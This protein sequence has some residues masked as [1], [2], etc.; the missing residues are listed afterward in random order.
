MRHTLLSTTGLIGTSVVLLG[1]WSGDA[2]AWEPMRSDDGLELRWPAQTEFSICPAVRSELEQSAIL[3]AGVWWNQ[4]G[5]RSRL[6]VGVGCALSSSDGISSVVSE[7]DQWPAEFGPSEL[8]VAL[9][10]HTFTPDGTITDSDILLNAVEFEFTEHGDEQSFSAEHVVAHELG[11]VLGLGHPCGDTQ[12]QW[13]SCFALSSE[14]IAELEPALMFP[15]RSVGPRQTQLAADDLEGLTSLFALSQAPSPTLCGSRA[16]AQALDAS[17]IPLSWKEIDTLES[18]LLAGDEPL[19]LKTNR[20][21]LVRTDERDFVVDVSSL[22][23]CVT[24]ST[25]N[26]SDCT[27]S[28]RA[29]HAVPPPAAATLMFLFLLHG[30]RRRSP[31][32]RTRRNRSQ[33]GSRSLTPSSCS[34][35]GT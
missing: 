7:T 5:L 11:H 23:P 8:M 2:K 10:Q 16:E 33:P 18:P 35:L 22:E 21:L 30:V 4:G 29:C 26:H 25:A 1:V 17:A 13:P 31:H 19:L 6:N 24:P 12:G 9:T 14:R 3:G 15:S 27:C 32:R 20:P 34:H 28:S